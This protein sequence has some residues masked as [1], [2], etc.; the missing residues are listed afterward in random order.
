L[1]TQ[2]IRQLA[3]I[4]EKAVTDG[5]GWAAVNW[6]VALPQVQGIL[7]SEQLEVAKT[8]IAVQDLNQAVRQYYSQ[9]HN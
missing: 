1:T 2:Q 4:L 3:P 7:T 8:W 6:D 5:K 9:S